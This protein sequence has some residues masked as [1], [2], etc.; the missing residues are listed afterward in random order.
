MNPSPFLS[1]IFIVTDSPLYQNPTSCFQFSPIYAGMA[2][3]TVAWLSRN[4]RP[5]AVTNGPLAIRA[6]NLFSAR[7]LM[8]GIHWLAYDDDS[9]PT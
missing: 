3:A 1:P 6:K 8:F 7:L 4:L 2:P 9:D 5:D